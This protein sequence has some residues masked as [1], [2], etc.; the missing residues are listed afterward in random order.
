LKTYGVADRAAAKALIRALKDASPSVRSMSA[1]ALSAV[2]PPAGIAI[3]D[4]AISIVV[5]SLENAPPGS[6]YGAALAVNDMAC[7]VKSR[8]AAAVP[9]L[10]ETLAARD[11]ETRCAA[12]ASLRHIGPPSVRSVPT[13]LRLLKEDRREEV[14][15]SA[16]G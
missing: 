2:A 9:A 7:V 13:L 15:R 14:R 4:E 6:R 1:Q 10:I 5:R 11:W 16:A 3:P 12:L 8:A